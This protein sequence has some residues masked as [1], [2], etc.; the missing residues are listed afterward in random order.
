MAGLCR[1]FELDVAHSRP[2]ALRPFHRTG[3]DPPPSPSAGP[4]NPY[5]SRATH[6][7]RAA[8][9]PPQPAR[10]GVVAVSAAWG[11]PVQGRRP[12]CARPETRPQ[13]DPDSPCPTKPNPRPSARARRGHRC[14]TCRGGG[15][16]A[17]RRVALAL[18]RVPLGSQNHFPQPN[19]ALEEQTPMFRRDWRV[20]GSC[21]RAVPATSG[22]RSEQSPRYERDVTQRYKVKRT[23]SASHVATRSRQE[24]H[25]RDGSQL[26]ASRISRP[27]ASW[28]GKMR[29]SSPI[30]A[31]P[32]ARAATR[33]GTCSPQCSAFRAPCIF[34]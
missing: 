19:C 16:D 28:V 21:R 25:S 13:P 29:D 4:A 18:S 8:G 32:P 17:G 22:P 1:Q 30:P 9:Q 14:R 26:G 23:R 24:R 11:P 5:A 2:G 12:G 6:R 20:R 34:I 27:P 15:C 33:V 7:M 3:R 31:S 10:P